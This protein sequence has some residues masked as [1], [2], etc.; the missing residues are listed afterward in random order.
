MFTQTVGMTA[1]DW[2]ISHVVKTSQTIDL[3]LASLSFFTG[4]AV[5]GLILRLKAKEVCSDP[6]FKASLG[7]YQKWKKRHSIS[8]RTKT[9]LAQR[10]P[11]D[12]EEKTVQ[13]HRFV[14]ALR[15]RY[16]HSLSRLFNMDET[17]MRFELPSSRT[18]EFSGS[19]TVPVKSC[20]A[21][22]RSFTVTLAVAADGQKLPPSVIFKGVRTPRDLAVPDSV[23][24]SFHKKGWM[25]EKGKNLSHFISK[26]TGNW[27]Y[28]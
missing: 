26:L 1:S 17:P 5:S 24:V 6:D 11:Q 10:L 15:Q 16:G 19:R 25:D 7:W 23:R 2:P 21:E 3:N 27:C 20:G 22:K 12:L 8:L 14:I 18:L 9:T 4:I 28:A 13:F